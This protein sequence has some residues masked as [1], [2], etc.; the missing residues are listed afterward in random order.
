VIVPIVS[1]TSEDVS[2]CIRV[3]VF[4]TV[5]FTFTQPYVATTMDD[6]VHGWGHPSIVS[7][8]I[9]SDEATEVPS[10]FKMILNAGLGMMATISIDNY[11]SRGTW[12]SLRVRATIK[13]LLELLCIIF[14][15]SRLARLLSHGST[16]DYREDRA[17]RPV[18][19]IEN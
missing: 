8:A 11:R 13:T 15:H 5:I 10:I 16:I 19:N 7:V 18:R 6:E 3:V 2:L 4:F 12:I 14:C 17:G 1:A 9:I